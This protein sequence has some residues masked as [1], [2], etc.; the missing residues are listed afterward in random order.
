M[1]SCNISCSDRVPDR[2]GDAGPYTTREE[3]V[4]KASWQAQAMCTARR[5]SGSNQTILRVSPHASAPNST[6]YMLHATVKVSDASAA[7]VWRRCE[8]VGVDSS[9]RRNRTTRTSAGETQSLQNPWKRGQP[10]LDTIS[11]D[12]CSQL[13]LGTLLRQHLRIQRVQ[14][15]AVLL[16][17][18]RPLELEPV[19]RRQHRRPRPPATA[20]G[21][22]RGATHVG[23]RSSFS[24]V[25][26]SSINLTA[27]TLS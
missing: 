7:C 4:C 25:K 15:L 16:R 20:D 19:R 17:R 26:G 21:M 13:R 18:L 10:P 14:M 3:T 6:C 23:V 5:S 22:K 1:S 9:A 24:I 8:G 2:T 12:D 11:N 27:L